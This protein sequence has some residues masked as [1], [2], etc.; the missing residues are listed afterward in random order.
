[1]NEPLLSPTHIEIMG[2]VVIPLL[3]AWLDQR[4]Q[5][6]RHHNA[7]MEQQREQHTENTNRLTKIETTLEPIADWWNEARSRE[8]NGGSHS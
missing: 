2:M 3:L 1:M 8:R 4:R 6:E 7:W 5:S